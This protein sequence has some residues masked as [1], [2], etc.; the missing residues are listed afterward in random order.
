[1]N[2]ALPQL[3]KIHT[4]EGAFTIDLYCHFTFSL[5]FVLQTW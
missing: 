4:P 5:K 1:M 3:F 2:L